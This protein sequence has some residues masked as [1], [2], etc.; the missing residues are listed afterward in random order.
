MIK[1]IYK[2]FFLVLFTSCSIS[3]NFYV[4]NVQDMTQMD[5]SAFIYA[6]PRTVVTVEVT[7]IRHVTIPGP[8]HEYADEFLGIQNVPHEK[9]M[10]WTIDHTNLTSHVEVDPDYY[11]SVKDPGSAVLKS[12]MFQLTENGLIL[13]ASSVG[14]FSDKLETP[15]NELSK[16]PFT[17]LSVKRN[18]IHENDTVYKKIIRNNSIVKVPMVKK[19]WTKKTLEEKAEE[20]ANFIVKLRKRRFKL[21]TGQSESMPGGDG[22]EAALEELN[23]LEA[24]YLALFTGKTIDE[25]F[26]RTFQVV[27]EANRQLT[28][29]V[30]FRFSE[31]DGFFESNNETNGKPVVIEITDRGTTKSLEHLAYPYSGVSAP[32]V[33]F[34]RIPDRADVRL[35]YGS[36]IL[37][38][39]DMNIYQHGAVVPYIFQ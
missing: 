34:Y 39:A 12:R 36:S 13:D 11:Y 38:E 24:E 21:L 5:K 25:V 30:L 7:A 16:I 32:N 14:R 31:T 27:P 26:T 23:D 15:S 4:T 1:K 19:Q 29:T 9:Q 3:K 10:L 8:Y 2:V 33:L 6:L 28:R 20:A 22:M 37:A 18:I 35:I 17:D